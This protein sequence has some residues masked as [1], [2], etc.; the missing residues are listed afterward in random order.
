[1][2]IICDSFLKLDNISVEKLHWSLETQ[3][4]DLATGDIGLAPLPDNRFARGKC[5]YKILQYMAAGLPTIASPVGANRQYIEQSGAG[6]LAENENQW[7]DAIT[8]LVEDEPSRTQMAKSAE[9][10]VKQFDRDVLG[11]RLLKV[12]TDCA[13]R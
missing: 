7:L 4:A 10:F 1:L 3:A 8:R 5:G 6:L 12:I 2:R 9:T 13:R 11:K